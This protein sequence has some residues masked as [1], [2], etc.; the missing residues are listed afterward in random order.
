MFDLVLPWK[1][2]NVNLE[3]VVNFAKLLDSNCCGSSADVNFRIHFTETPEVETIEAI[4][5]LW[6]GLTEES[7]E[8]TSYKTSAQIQEEAANAQAIALASAKSKLAALGLNDEEV[9]AIIGR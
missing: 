1:E 6:D 9:A 8:V 7:E 4:Q 2:F 5:E 3:S